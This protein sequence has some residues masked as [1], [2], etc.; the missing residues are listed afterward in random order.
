VALWL[1]AGITL[2]GL[3]VADVRRARTPEAWLLGCWVGGTLVFAGFLNWTLNGRSILP[4]APAAAIL[5]ARRFDLLAQSKGVTLRGWM[6][7][8]LLLT[9]LLAL[10]VARADHLWAKA[11]RL[12]A[13][14]ILARYAQVPGNLWFAGHWGFQ[15]YMAVGRGRVLDVHRSRIEA[16]DMLVLPLSNPGADVPQSSAGRVVNRLLV[17]GPSWVATM[18]HETGGGFYSSV[19]G[20]LPFDFWRIPPEEFIVLQ[21]PKAVPPLAPP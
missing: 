16:G 8:T 19:W 21:F 4:L 6:N 11:N 17:A 9:G 12:A 5:L 2:V 20:P 13:E 10:A 15:H 18:S 14:A 3:M 1:V 7:G